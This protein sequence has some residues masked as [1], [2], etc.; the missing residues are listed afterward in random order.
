MEKNKPEVNGNSDKNIMT[1][2]RSASENKYLHKDFHQSMNLLLDYIYKHFGGEEVIRYL[3]QF[4]IAYHHPLHLLL[5]QGDMEAL[6]RY[7]VDIYEKEE[8]PVR[9]DLTENALEIEQTACP[10]ITHIRSLGQTPTPLYIETYRSVYST[11]CDGTKLD[12]TLVFFDNETG[13]CKQLF[14]KRELP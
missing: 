7:F 6:A 2:S 12:Y 11:L 10:G 8:W 5:K 4:T 9:V 14:T 1:M 13:A 3:K